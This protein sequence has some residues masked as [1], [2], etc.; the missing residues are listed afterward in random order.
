MY[1]CNTL[2]LFCFTQCFLVLLWKCLLKKV[3]KYRFL[4]TKSY[5]TSFQLYETFS[6]SFIKLSN[7]VPKAC[8]REEM[9]TLVNSVEFASLLIKVNYRGPGPWATCEFLD[10]SYFLISKLQIASKFEALVKCANR[11]LI[12]DV[13]LQVQ[14]LFGLHLHSCTHRLRPR[15]PLLPPA[16]GLTYKG[17]IGQ[18]RY[19]TSPHDPLGVNIGFSGGGG[20]FFIIICRQITL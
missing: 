4:C 10:T 3:Q 2:Y 13:N 19:T 9:S 17:A 16:F 1:T 8:V 11:R 7:L 6:L 5:N 12:M 14:C 18:P 20:V 15:N